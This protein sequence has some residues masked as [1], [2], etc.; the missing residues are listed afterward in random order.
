MSMIPHWKPTWVEVP[1]T[2]QVAGAYEANDVVGGTLSCDAYNVS[3]GGY[4]G[5]VRLVDGDDEK[6]A[7]KLYVFN[8]APSAIADAAPHAPTEADWLKHIGTIEIAT[9]D[10]DAS[11][12]DACAFVYGRGTGKTG[13]VAFD[14][15]PNGKLYFRLVCTAT[16]QYTAADDLTL[17]VLLWLM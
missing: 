16:P 11:G 10:Y 14:N 15:L 9:A 5:A 3:G 12:N 17:H 1:V 6:A 13:E 7:F 8:A 4:I 2:V